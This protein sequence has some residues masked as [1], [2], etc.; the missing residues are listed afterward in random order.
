MALE[1]CETCTISLAA[2]KA[3]APSLVP[4][5]WSSSSA[6]SSSASLFSAS[7]CAAPPVVA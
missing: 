2:E 5:F 3:Y 6:K 7:F 1:S 4:A